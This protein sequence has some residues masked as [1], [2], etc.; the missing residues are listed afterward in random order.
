[1]TPDYALQDLAALIDRAMPGSRRT[2]PIVEVNGGFGIA[3]PAGG[4][5]VVW[6]APEEPWFLRM[7]A[8]IAH[9]APDI[10]AAL[11]WVNGRNSGFAYGQFYASLPAEGPA[12]ANV[13][14]QTCVPSTLLDEAPQLLQGHVQQLLHLSTEVAQ[15]EPA[16]CLA[17]VGGVAFRDTDADRMLLVT[18][19]FG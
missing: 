16:G 7:T 4:Q 11:R 18:A 13:V 14:W 10:P 12:R 2:A 5:V 17:A 6:A 15:H 9:G 3:V 1:M 19:S 8:G